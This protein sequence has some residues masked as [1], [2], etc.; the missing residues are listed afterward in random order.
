MK[1][2]KAASRLGIVE[3]LEAAETCEMLKEGARIG[4]SG[5]RRW[6]SANPV[7]STV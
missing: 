3:K 7:S 5:E 6:A 1:L 2:A 4:V